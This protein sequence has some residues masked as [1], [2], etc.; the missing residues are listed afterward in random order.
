MSIL[1]REIIGEI[2]FGL[3]VLGVF[4]VMY[5]LT[6]FLSRL[7]AKWRERKEKKAKGE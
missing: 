1:V 7:T 3:L 6:I 4:C 2:A 5:F